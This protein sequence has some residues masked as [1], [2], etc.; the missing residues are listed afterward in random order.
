MALKHHIAGLIKQPGA[1]LGWVLSIVL[2]AGFIA[3]PHTTAAGFKIGF[4]DTGKAL[5]MHPRFNAVQQ[6]LQTYQTTRN[7][8]L[9]AYRKPNLTDAEKKALVAKNESISND[10]KKKE[11]E[12]LGP[13]AT[14]VATA[15]KTVGNTGGYEAIVE[16][17]SIHYG[18][19][20]LG[21]MIAAELAKKKT[22]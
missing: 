12:L 17:A 19:V 9:D 8:E 7:K 13:L 14:D 21:P 11:D 15:I 2:I 4:V 18:G 22:S 5:R 6:Q 3:T 1:L 16:A 10:I 20:D